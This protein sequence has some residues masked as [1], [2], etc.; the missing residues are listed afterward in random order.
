MFGSV[1]TLR[2]MPDEAV[3]DFADLLRDEKGPLARQLKWSTILM[4]ELERD[5]SPEKYDGEKFRM[6]VILAPQA[7]TGMITE[8][9]AL[10]TPQLLEKTKTRI[11]VGIVTIPVSFTTK[12]M[13]VSDNRDNAWLDAVEGKMDEAEKAFRRTINEQF[14][15]VGDAL[16]AAITAG[17]GPSTTVTVGTAA[18]WYQLY[19]GRIID[20]RTRS[21]GAVI[22]NGVK[23]VSYDEVAGTVTLNTSVT[24][25]TNEGLY[26]QGSYGN[27]IAGYGN[28]TATTG[29]FQ[30][31][32]RATFPQWKGTDVTPSGTGP[33]DPT[34]AIFD[35]AER[36]ARRRSGD[37]PDFYIMDPAVK[38]KFT[39]LLT[40]QAQ[41][42]GAEGT[43]E[44]GWVGAKYRNKTYL[45]EFDM[46]SKTVYG[47]KKEDAL[48]LT[49]DD[50]P[51]WD[52]RDGSMFKRFARTLPLEAWLVWM[53]QL[54]FKRCN[55]AVKI[56]NLTPAT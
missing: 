11:D 56:G 44:T 10:N 39:Q 26:I 14:C 55:S 15:G 5:S 37:G 8:T 31:I 27:A 45:D 41:W 24:V 20:V 21:N 17:S 52:E 48:I 54:G 19:E 4:S 46:P 36:I 13:E 25:T 49:V 3:A 38:D 47:V 32:N 29:T 9:T 42:N 1:H 43:L 51:D 7:G 35:K 33:F 12:L 40:V 2:F 34:I 30:E 22:A 28:A 23:I 16:I 18:N 50:G 53:L 6:G